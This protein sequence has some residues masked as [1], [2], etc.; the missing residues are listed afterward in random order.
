MTSET[1]A[2]ANIQTNRL[3]IL[4]KETGLEDTKA[5][6]IL[7]QF[8]GYFKD[9]AELEAKAKTIVVT[10]GTQL[11]EMKQAREYRLA[12]K[13]KRC[14]VE[15][16]RVKLKEQSLREGKAIDGIANVIKALIVPIEQYCETQEKFAEIAEAKRKAALTEERKT[17]LAQWNV[18]T[19]FYDLGSMPNE[20]YVALCTASE[21]AYMQKIEAQRKAEADRIAQQ[22]AEEEHKRKLAEE[23]DRLRKEAA[24]N[25]AK[26]DAERK[27]REEKERA[28][29]AKQE[30]IRKEQE[31]KLEAE[32]KAKEEAEKKLA[33]IKAKEEADRKAQAAADKKARRAPDKVKLQKLIDDLCSI[34]YPDVSD[35]ELQQFVDDANNGVQD[36]VDFLSG[37]INQ[38]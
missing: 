24:E 18:D 35:D 16:T 8:Q 15:N 12:L 37:A 26:L 6:Y 20:Q 4:V 29:R 38:I 25:Q 14:D 33:D 9:A 7:E 23:N 10:D 27:E 30:A 34:Q 36:I 11:T 28:E 2:K 17:Q 31:A 21:M 19:S 1:E 32:R 5:H 3:E 13:Q 22:K